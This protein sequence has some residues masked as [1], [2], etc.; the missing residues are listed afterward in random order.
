MNSMM[1]DK[2]KR[3]IKQTISRKQI[4]LQDKNNLKN[5]DSEAMKSNHVYIFEIEL[6]LSHILFVSRNIHGLLTFEIINSVT[7]VRAFC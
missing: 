3:K 7:R 1:H 6:R 4:N 5:F 2:N